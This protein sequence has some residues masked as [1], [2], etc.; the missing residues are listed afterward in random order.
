M[1]NENQEFLDPLE[2]D[3]DGLRDDVDDEEDEQQHEEDDSQ[4]DDHEDEDSDA[5]DPT[6]DGA[7]ESTP[8]PASRRKVTYRPSGPSRL[9]PPNVRDRGD[10]ERQA[11]NERKRRSRSKGLAEGPLIAKF[12]EDLGKLLNA[13]RQW[14]V[15]PHPDPKEKLVLMARWR[16][17]G[18]QAE[19][20]AK[21]L[22]E[23]RN[24]RSRSHKLSSFFLNLP[25]GFCLA[26]SPLLCETEDDDENRQ[27]RIENRQERIDKLS[28]V[29]DLAFKYRYGCT[30]KQRVDWMKGKDLDWFDSAM[31]TT[32]GKLEAED[33]EDESDRDWR[34]ELGDCLEY[35]F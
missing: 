24:S 11:W 4:N 7:V 2:G 12:N 33:E 21:E 6:A 29:H 18:H 16:R 9:K 14:H 31:A 8:K 27:E 13:H 30:N 25:L 35:D 10:L 3:D 28:L 5:F 17:L 26:F 20:T 22:R 34:E 19:R 1:L 32:V 23:Y 15:V